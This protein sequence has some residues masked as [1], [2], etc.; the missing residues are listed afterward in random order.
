M[1]ILRINNIIYTYTGMTHNL[2]IQTYSFK[3]ILELFHIDDYKITAAQIKKA[4]KIVLMTHPD[5]SKL[6]SDYFLFYKKAFDVLLNYYNEHNK[7]TQEVIPSVY[8]PIS[9][10]DDIQTTNIKDKIKNANQNKFQKE[11]NTLFEENMVSKIDDS[12]N[13]WFINE[14]INEKYETT[15]HV[16][17]NNMG[18]MFQQFKKNN[19]EIVVHKGVQELHHSSGNSLYDDDDTQYCGSDVFGKLKFDDLRKVHKDHTIFDVCDSDYNKMKKYT[20][21]EQIMS[22]RGRQNVGPMDKAEAQKILNQRNSQHA[23]KMIQ[24]Q[25]Q[26]NLKSMEYSNKNKQV[27]GS[28]FMRI[29]N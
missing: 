15:Q 20:S 12:K 10:E 5:K 26:S 11:F 23:E 21:V 25:H 6:S 17:A 1:Y 9:Q 14:D 29:T 18:Q 19:Q 2:D 13:N 28:L 4:K 3:D 22:D 16:N 27:M 24:K 8:Q 7:Q